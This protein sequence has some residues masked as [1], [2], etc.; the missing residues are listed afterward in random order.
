M[1]LDRY[2]AAPG[3]KT[4]TALSLELGVSKGRL[5]QLRHSKDWAA[6]LALKIEAATDGALNASLLSQVVARARE[7]QEAA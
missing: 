1:T 4:L 6:D 5:S 7:G 3:A 2:L